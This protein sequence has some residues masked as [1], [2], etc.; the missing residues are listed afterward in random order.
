MPPSPPVVVGS[1]LREWRVGEVCS[2]PG[3][4]L[5]CS[6][7]LPQCPYHPLSHCVLLRSSSSHSPPGYRSP[8][9]ISPRCCIGLV[10]YFN[11]ISMEL[12]ISTLISSKI[13]LCSIATSVCACYVYRQVLNH[14]TIALLVR[15]RT[16][17]LVGF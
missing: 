6:P 15:Y 12:L 11:Q 17:D 7:L 3:G 13:N 16:S 9:T 8:S 1:L 14:T 2:A 5:S 4:A 10:Q